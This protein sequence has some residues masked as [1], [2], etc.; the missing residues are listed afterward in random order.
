MTEDVNIDQEIENMKKLISWCL[1]KGFTDKKME[2]LIMDW[3]KAGGD[4]IP[5][6]II[7]NS[8]KRRPK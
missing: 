6:D 4:L 5:K 2:K 1:Q 3:N 7:T 8:I